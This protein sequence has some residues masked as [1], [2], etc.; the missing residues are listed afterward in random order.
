MAVENRKRFE[1]SRAEK[2]LEVISG[3]LQEISRRAA[4]ESLWSRERASYL[5]RTFERFGKDRRQKNRN[6]GGKDQQSPELV[7]AE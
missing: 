3:K 4:K 6:D 1:A 2:E 5:A 7:A